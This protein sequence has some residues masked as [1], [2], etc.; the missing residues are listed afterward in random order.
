M[1]T[2]F[3]L[4]HSALSIQRTQA[5]LAQQSEWTCVGAAQTLEG[6]Q[7]ALRQFRPDVLLADL[8]LADG[9]VS[10]L[11]AALHRDEPAP[12]AD[13]RTWGMRPGFYVSGAMVLE[14]VRIR[15]PRV[16][17]YRLPGDERLLFESLRAGAHAYLPDLGRACVCVPALDRLMQSR[18]SMSPDLARACLA[19]F[20]LGRRPVAQS[21]TVLAAHDVRPLA[22]GQ[23]LRHCDLHLL[24]LICAGWLSGEIAKAWQLPEMAVEQRIALL[25][26]VLQAQHDADAA[27]AEAAVSG[28]FR[29]QAAGYR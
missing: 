8:R 17:L 11:L 28:P 12:L 10:E 25:Y 21:Q 4:R 23:R 19:F 3:L 26:L 1:S 14:P 5:E 6:A 13:S 2:V 16:L 20:G 9:P 22:A 29:Q 15:P 24:S 7:E 18:A 27:K